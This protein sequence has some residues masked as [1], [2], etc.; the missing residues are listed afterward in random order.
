[1]PDHVAPPVAMNL[2]EALI[3]PEVRPYGL[4]ELV[5]SA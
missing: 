3:R 5:V 1:M 2:I 4:N